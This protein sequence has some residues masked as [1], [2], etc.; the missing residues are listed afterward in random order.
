MF[1]TKLPKTKKKL[2][3]KK[4][5]SVSIRFIG[6]SDTVYSCELIQAFP[7]SMGTIELADAS[8]SEVVEL[9]VQLSYRNWRS[10]KQKGR[11]TNEFS[12]KIDR[13]TD[14]ALRNQ[15]YVMGHFFLPSEDHCILLQISLSGANYFIAPITN[16]WGT[17]NIVPIV[18]R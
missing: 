6:Q 16:I 7:T 3:Q 9:T 14:G 8:M 10:S 12:F 4:I 5:S 17:T 13:D 15:V 1:M 18:D 11:I 2:Q